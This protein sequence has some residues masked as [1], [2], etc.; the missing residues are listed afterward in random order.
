M[1]G[2]LHQ[3]SGLPQL[4]SD[5]THRTILRCGIP[6]IAPCACTT[7]STKRCVSTRPRHTIFV[8]GT[9]PYAVSALRPSIAP[10]A[11]SVLR[12]SIAPSYRPVPIPSAPAR[13]LEHVRAPR[14]HTGP[15]QSRRVQP[16]R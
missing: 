7:R 5:V 11:S 4:S 1:R 8:P 6:G 10:Y 12:P 16:R 14:W 9:A 2:A 15:R 3:R 13:T